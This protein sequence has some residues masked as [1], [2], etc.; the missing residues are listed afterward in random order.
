MHSQ[1][2]SR[3]LA[4]F[5]LIELLVVLSIIAILVGLLLPALAYVR[6]EARTIQCQNNLRHIGIA[7]HSYGA[8]NRDHV[9]AGPPAFGDF[10]EPDIPSPVLVVIDE[11]DRHR[12]TAHGLLWDQHYLRELEVFLCPTAEGFARRSIEALIRGEEGQLEE[13]DPTAAFS[14]YLYRQLGE[15]TGKR[16]GGLGVNGLGEPARALALHATADL[17]DDADVW[18]RALSTVHHS[19]REVSILGD[20]GHVSAPPEALSDG[21]FA[22]RGGDFH[23]EYPDVLRLADRAVVGRLRE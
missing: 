20:D 1:R 6:R 15:A 14:S 10:H 12:Y 13:G 22:F 8:D 21:G 9:L 11:N 3:R 23:E 7:L 18:A 17:D 19:G 5:T 2:S 4:A 16:L